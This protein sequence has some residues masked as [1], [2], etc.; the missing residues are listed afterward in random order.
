[1]TFLLLTP[2]LLTLSL[3][4]PSSNIPTPFFE[5]NHFSNFF[6]PPPFYHGSSPSPAFSPSSGQFTEGFFLSL[7]LR[8]QTR[9]YDLF[10]FC[11]TCLVPENDDKDFPFPFFFHSDAFSSS[12]RVRSP[13]LPLLSELEGKRVPFR[14]G[15]QSQID[16]EGVDFLPFFC[17]G[18]RY[19]W[20]AA[21]HPDR[22]PPS[23]ISPSFLLF[24][25]PPPFF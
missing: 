1:M 18:F 12:G 19:A 5:M 22:H 17:P 3:E 10:F 21:P 24:F 15:S 14:L 2:F 8:C 23:L 4:E 16:I 6:F 7:S 11:E 25:S 9:R 20:C 13:W